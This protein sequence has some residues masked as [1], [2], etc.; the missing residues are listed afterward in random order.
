LD[1]FEGV[2]RFGRKDGDELI[3]RELFGSAMGHETFHDILLFSCEV[4]GGAPDWFVL[5]A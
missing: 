3:A 5:T 4:A 1:G 2:R